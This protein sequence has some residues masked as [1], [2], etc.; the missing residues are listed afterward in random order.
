MTGSVDYSEKSVLLVDSSGNLRSTVKS[1]LQ[2]MG[3][4]S[5]VATSISSRV[6]DDIAAGDFDII[7]LGHNINDSYSGLRLLEEA[8]YK[9]LIKPTC[10]W[11]LMTSDA[12]QQSV[13]FAIEIQPDELLTKPFTLN[14]LSKRIHQ[15]CLQR[16]ALEP[17]ERAIERKAVNRAVK[18]CDTLFQP[19][20]ASYLQVQM[21]KGRLLL[22]QEQYADAKTAFELVYRQDSSLLSGYQLAECHYR[23][24]QFDVAQPLLQKLLQQ[25][26]LL[27]PAYDLQARVY[28]AQGELEA[29]QNVLKKAV[30]QSP[31]AIQ[32]QMEL[33]RLSMRN[34]D[35][36]QA[37][38][39]YRRSIRLGENSYLDSAAAYFK[40]A[41]VQRLQMEQAVGI[42]QQDKLADIERLLEK[43][44]QRFQRD[45]TV[46]IQAQ[47]LRA[48]VQ[49]SLG[50]ADEAQRCYERALQHAE[51]SG[52]D[53]DLDQMQAQILDESVPI[54]PAP[55]ALSIADEKTAGKQLDP[56]M[57][58]KVNRIGVRNYLADKPG[59]AIRYFGLAFEYDPNNA[60]AL[61][62]LAQ[63]FLEAAR[64][65]PSRSE[66]R[67]KMFERYLQLSKRLPVIG[68]E[69]SKQELLQGLSASGLTA[70]AEGPLAPL[71]K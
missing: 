57:S 40:L 11:I 42:E 18:L 13:L 47:L 29:A 27:I 45:V 56:V 53:V 2:S 52:D 51:H 69:K 59:Q 36:G 8:R 43:A 63:L 65:T 58:A 35:L 55:V 28:E 22:D 21:I 39:A 9:G 14:A 68:D 60:R 61:L 25:H 23:L 30:S 49:E 50:D 4:A 10:S 16:A 37:E 54:M 62:N 46:R 41:N 31:L 6:L 70:L 1:M 32:R 5:V 15:L 20:D 19:S 71:L 3:F 7:L 44:G 17:I 66:E 38:K 24:G 64:D 33:G 26:P 12:S 34:S 48:K 67:M